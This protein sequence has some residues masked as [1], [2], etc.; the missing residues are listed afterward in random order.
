MMADEGLFAPVVKGAKVIMG[1]KQLKKVRAEVIKAHG[2][3]INTFVDTGVDLPFGKI[4]LTKMFEYADA[5]DSGFLDK[6][7]I[8]QASEKLGFTW[9][10][11]EKEFKKFMKK[12]DENGD[13]Q[14]DFN[15]FITVAPAQLK[16][17]LTKLAK[18]NG[19]ALGFLV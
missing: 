9:F 15:E 16:L 18:T 3:A 2:S 13:D 10:G 14:V 11:D 8:V 7:E 12:A 17:N 19:H 4:V 6:E 1:E 5:D